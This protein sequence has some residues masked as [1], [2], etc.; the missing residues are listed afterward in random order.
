MF[1]ERLKSYRGEYTDPHLQRISKGRAIVKEVITRLDGGL[2]YH[3]PSSRAKRDVCV[4]DVVLLIDKMK[5]E[6]LLSAH[7][8]RTHGPSLLTTAANPVAGT[9]G[10]KVKEWMLERI[11]MCQVRRYYKQ[12]SG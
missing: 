12:F 5:D 7:G 9:S 11:G 1:K 4:T 8:S 3:A 2:Q 6:Q 10:K